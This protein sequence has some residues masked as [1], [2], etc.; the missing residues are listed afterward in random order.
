MAVSVNARIA[1]C[2]ERINEL[3][4]ELELATTDK[5]AAKAEKA[6]ESWKKKKEVAQAG[7]LKSL[8][9]KVRIDDT[10][11]VR[12]T[13]QLWEPSSP[14]S[15]EVREVEDDY[16]TI[17]NDLQATTPT[18]SQNDDRRRLLL[19]NIRMLEMSCGLMHDLGLD[20]A[21]TEDLEAH[22][23]SIKQQFLRQNKSLTSLAANMYVGLFV[24]GSHIINHFSDDL[25]FYIDQETMNTTF[26][27]ANTLAN[28]Q[29]AIAE[30]FED[31]PEVRQYFT[32]A[33]RGLPKLLALT[34]M[35]TLPAVRPGTIEKKC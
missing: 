34:A 11:S 6:L 12:S 23:A 25:G 14:P 20:E 33:S 26:H 4:A 15:R 22:H 9:K 30:I 2:D 31:N 18:P 10:V 7:L 28:M 32:V 8:E 16:S 19:K 27:D 21:P 17:L 3:E 24:N 29:D 1:K 5:E 35:A 13:S